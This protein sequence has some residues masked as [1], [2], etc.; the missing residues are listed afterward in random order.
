[1]SKIGI[2]FEGGGMRGLY[3]A[4]VIEE[5]I[6]LNLNIDTGI[7]VSAGA[8]F[9]VNLLSKQKKR[10]LNYNKEFC[11]DK[12]YMGFSSLIKTGNIINEEFAYHEVPFKYY[13][14]DDEEYKKS[15]IKF[16]AVA[17]NVETGKPEYIQI[18]NASEQI[19]VI[20]ATSAMPFVSKMVEMDGKKYLDGAIGDSIPVKKIFEM[21]CDKVIVVLTRVEGYRKKKG[22]EPFTNFF[23]RKYSNLAKAVNH[24]YI[25][26]NETLDYI[27]E[28]E[29]NGKIVV[30]RPSKNLKLKRVENNPDRLQDMYDLGVNDFKAK[31]KDIKNYLKIKGSLS[32]S[33]GRQ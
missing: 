17:T 26:Y 8:C 19:D 22:L 24:R 12:R 4:G 13:P 2:V 16:Y 9:G 20:H 31:L 33:V 14:F 11:N 29:E 3:T 27:K 7:G 18:K 28:L 21:G 1:M 15:K 5:L 6:D 30:I 10:V 25:M 23:Y 32:N